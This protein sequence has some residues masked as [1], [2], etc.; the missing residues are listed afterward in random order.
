MT[1][2]QKLKEVVRAATDG[3]GVDAILSSLGSERA[4]QDLDLLAVNGGLVCLL[5]LPDPGDACSPS[6]PGLIHEVAFGSRSPIRGQARARGLGKNKRT[7]QEWWMNL[8]R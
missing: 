4:T 5:G 2:I 6:R 1:T 8:P 3:R 7:W